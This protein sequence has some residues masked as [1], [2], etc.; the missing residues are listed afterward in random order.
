MGA[1]FEM[2]FFLRQVLGSYRGLDATRSVRTS[3]HLG[4]IC[5]KC[6]G[7]RCSSLKQPGTQIIGFRLLLR[8]HTRADVGLAL[9][10]WVRLT[11]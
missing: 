1:D 11:G 8:H 3:T 4:D 9:R 7:I 6:S 2:T 5:G 10:A